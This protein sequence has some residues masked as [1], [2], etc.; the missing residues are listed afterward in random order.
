M[1]RTSSLSS[2]ARPRRASRYSPSE[3]PDAPEQEP[4]ETLIQREARR[5]RVS[6]C[7]ERSRAPIDPVHA[8]SNTGANS[9]LPEEYSPLRVE[10]VDNQDRNEHGKSDRDNAPVCAPA[11]V[12]KDSSASPPLSPNKMPPL[13]PDRSPTARS[14]S[15]ALAAVD[16]LPGVA[17]R[18]NRQR[19][20]SKKNARQLLPELEYF[21]RTSDVTEQ[22]RAAAVAAMCSRAAALLEAQQAVSALA[23]VEAAPRVRCNDERKRTAAWGGRPSSC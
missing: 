3:P 17:Q 2:L 10:E 12:D 4:C 13:H 22:Q 16:K 23:M 15:P 5:R 19:V 8:R 1:Q 7:P 9:I 21:E 18:R 6:L 14:L 11:D 20:E